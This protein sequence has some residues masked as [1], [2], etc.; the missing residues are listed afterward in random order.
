MLDDEQRPRP[1]GGE[2]VGA[3]DPSMP[4]EEQEALDSVI[5]DETIIEEL[6]ALV[7]DAGI[8]ATAELAFQRT[9]AKLA[10]RN[11]VA[12]LAFVV[13]AIILLHIS[14]IA[15]A[16]GLVIALEPLV[17]IWGA[18]GIV[19]GIML[20]SVAI[21]GLAAAR[22]GQLIAEMFESSKDEGDGA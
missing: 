16:V 13:L 15:L 20:L 21:L 18:I 22:R 11:I 4:S 2:P 5:E 17:T 9:R 3:P 14:I 12:V 10:G 1:A 6:S 19:V 8:Y 7:E